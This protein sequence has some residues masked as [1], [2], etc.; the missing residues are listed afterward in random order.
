[1][2]QSVSQSHMQAQHSGLLEEGEGESSGLEPRAAEAEVQYLAT[3]SGSKVTNECK[4]M[5]SPS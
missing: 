4:Q 2:C 3:H 1:M 5:E